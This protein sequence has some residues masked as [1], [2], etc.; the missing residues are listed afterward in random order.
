MLKSEG[1]LQGGCGCSRCG[2]SDRVVAS[3]DEGSG[4]FASGG[5]LSGEVTNDMCCDCD[6]SVRED[7]KLRSVGNCW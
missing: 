6:S 1:R 4:G 3:L 7:L 5:N 2:G